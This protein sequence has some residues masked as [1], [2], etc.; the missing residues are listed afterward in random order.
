MKA[1]QALGAAALVGVVA[2]SLA[3]VMG[4]VS[5]DA[6]KT[7]L[8]LLTAVWFAAALAPWAIGKQTGA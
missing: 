2:I 5:L 3:Y 7:V 8:L 6:C 4:S 1:I